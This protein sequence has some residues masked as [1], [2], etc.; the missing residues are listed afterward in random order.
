[1]AIQKLPRELVDHIIN[2]LSPLSAVNAQAAFETPPREYDQPVQGLW[3]AIFKK[4]DWLRQVTELGGNPVLIGPRLGDVHLVND[5]RRMPKIHMVLH[6]GSM[7]FDVSTK[8]MRK[9]FIL[10]LK[11]GIVHHESCED[12]AEITAGDDLTV[13]VSE[14]LRGHEWLEIQTRRIKQLFTYNNKCLQ[15]QYCFFN[16]KTIK[17]LQPEEIGQYKFWLS[18]TGGVL[19]PDYLGKYRGGGGGGG[20]GE[21]IPR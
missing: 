12:C 9:L 14:P 16:D 18:R 7:S 5:Y 19:R 20:G 1:M 10:C 21:F 15:S 11:E 8:P 3:S 4:E 17:L 6:S 2:Y 13:D